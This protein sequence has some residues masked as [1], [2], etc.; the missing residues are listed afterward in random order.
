MSLTERI[1]QL[2]QL[3][4]NLRQQLEVAEHHLPAINEQI[5]SLADLDI[6]AGIALLGTVVY[7]RAY[8]HDGPIDS[9]QILQAAILIP[10]GF[11]VCMWDSEEYFR[12]RQQPR[13]SHGTI[14]MKFV[15]F[16]ECGSAV[17]ALLLPHVEPLLDRLMQ[18]VTPN[19]R[20]NQA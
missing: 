12:V 10:Q 6:V 15:P 18:L 5:R 13:I 11:G 7:D 8:G 17:K 3:N 4:V 14:Q 20:D 2:Q 1:R 16:D 9:N 19:R